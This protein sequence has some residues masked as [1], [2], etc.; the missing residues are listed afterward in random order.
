MKRRAKE[1]IEKYKN[2]NIIFKATLW[3]TICSILQKGIYAPDDCRAV[4]TI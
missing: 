3:Y 1:L 4:W 2:A